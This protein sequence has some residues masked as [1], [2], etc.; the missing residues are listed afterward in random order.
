MVPAPD[1]EG[2]RQILESHFRNIPLAPGVDLG[3][4]A[5]GTP[6]A[7]AALRAGAR[8]GAALL[9]RPGRGRR[10]RGRAWQGAA[11]LGPLAQRGEGCRGLS[12]ARSQ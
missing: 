3:V 11:T 10:A 1:V 2:R 4:T 7:P 12:M 5:R 6:G 9:A 8:G